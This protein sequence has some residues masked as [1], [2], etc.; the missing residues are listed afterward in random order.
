L[1]QLR[2]VT[3]DPRR[4]SST[5]FAVTHEAATLPSGRA[6]VLSSDRKVAR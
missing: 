6:K 2:F 3:Q 4:K 5:P 1:D